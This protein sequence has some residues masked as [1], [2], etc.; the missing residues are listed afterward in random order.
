MRQTQ[1][2]QGRRLWVWGLVL[3]ALGAIATGFMTEAGREFYQRAATY[4]DQMS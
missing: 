4:L 2:T 3:A 1:A